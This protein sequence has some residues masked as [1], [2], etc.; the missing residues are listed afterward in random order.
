VNLA[1]EFSFFKEISF[2]LQ[3]SQFSFPW[4]NQK[5]MSFQDCQKD[6]LVIF[7]QKIDRKI[8]RFILKEEGQGRSLG[9]KFETKLF[10]QI[11]NKLAPK[12]LLS[13][14]LFFGNKKKT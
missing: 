6:Y 9:K 8:I 2:V 14:F 13:V 12:K 4:E 5:L 10:S 1:H 11:K 7:S 3:K